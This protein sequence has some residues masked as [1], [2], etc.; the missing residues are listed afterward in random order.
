MLNFAVRLR[1]DGNESL[2]EVLNIIHAAGAL[3]SAMA[4]AETLADTA[5][6][7]VAGLPDSPW[8]AA[9]QQLGRYSYRRDH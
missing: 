1:N 4:C 6:Q 3:D 2:A 7:A 9:L 5:L 8:L